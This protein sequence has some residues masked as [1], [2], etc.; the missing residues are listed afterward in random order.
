[1]TNKHIVTALAAI[2]LFS[3][4]ALSQTLQKE[5]TVDR[6]V[7]LTHRDANRLTTPPQISLPELSRPNLGFA[8]Y[9]GASDLTTEITTLPPSAYL[10]T[11]P[12][13]S[14]RG[15]VSLGY[16]PLR[17]IDLSAGYRLVDNDRTRANAFL[18]FDN[19]QYTGL[20]TMDWK[21]WKGEWH[22]RQATLTAGG[23]VH[24]LLA[25]GHA[26]EGALDYT[27]SN[28]RFPCNERLTQDVNTL[29]ASAVY[30]ANENDK[31]FSGGIN[32]TYFGY[33]CPWNSLYI[34]DDSWEGFYG[35]GDGKPARES[36]VSAYGSYFLKTGDLELGG[37]VVAELI[38][39]NTN[40]TTSFK[41]GNVIYGN[42]ESRS[43][44][45]LRLQPQALWH[46]HNAS[47]KLGVEVDVNFRLGPRLRFAPNISANWTPIDIVSLELIA[48]GGV[49]QNTLGSL[50]DQTPYQTFLAV[51]N[52]SYVPVDAKLTVTVGPKYG[53]WVQGW[54]GYS[55]ARDWLM[56]YGY[57]WHYENVKGYR[58]GVA[59]GYNWRDIA[60]LSL[61]YE[62]SPSKYEEGYYLNRDR[63]AKVAT[64]KLRVTPIKP[65]DITASFEGR[66]GR[67]EIEVVMPEGDISAIYMRRHELKRVIDLTFGAT[68]RFTPRLSFWARGE[69]LLNKG[70]IMLGNVTVQGTTAIVGASY[71]F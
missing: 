33:R 37:R 15:Y 14:T 44:G 30:V 29:N 55:V 60:S 59:T 20:S 61:S 13:D 47:A 43:Y 5:I 38:H 36:F 65:L 31:R 34:L 2:G 39:D 71:K 64:A 49:I 28:Y 7:V 54:L 45:T 19:N 51:Y 6:E 11:F 35:Q 66:G 16:F 41:Y 8:Y 22:P 52:H 1:M 70:W 18:Q 67:Q 58:A 4:A 9:N 42:G 69:N 50:Y 68:Y 62:H 12:T 3:P 40:R 53:A 17:R 10:D 25:N 21:Y 24:H 27:Y 46:S 63:A 57:I 56:P 32:Y 48:K 23:T 26:I